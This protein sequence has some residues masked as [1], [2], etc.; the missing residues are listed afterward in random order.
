L[1]YYF[2]FS[3]FYFLNGMSNTHVSIERVFRSESGQVLA[4][5]IGWLR[6]FELAEDV[7][8]DAF[9]EALEH[10]VATGV[11]QRP[12][13][14]LTQVARRKAV[15]RLRRAKHLAGSAALATLASAPELPEPDEIPDERL[16]L[17]CTCCHPALPLEAQ[18]ALTLQTLGGLN[19]AEIAYAFL[20]PLPTM[21]QR[22]VRAK[23]KIKAAGIPY[24][25]PSANQLGERLDAIHH[26]LYLIFTEGYG[27]SSGDALIRQEL[28]DEAIRLARILSVLIGHS[29]EPI[30]PAQHA[31]TLGLLAL[32]LL[33][34][35]RRV[36]RLD[37]EGALVLL[38]DQDRSRWDQAQIGMGKA[39]LAKALLM[40]Q[41][42][43]YQIQ[44]AISALHAEAARPEDTDWPQIAALYNS[45]QRMHNTPVI[46]LNRAVAIGMASGP[47]ASL[48]LL[49]QIAE[50]GDLQEYHPFHLALADTLRRLGRETEARASYR[51]ALDLCQ[52]RVERAAIAQQLQR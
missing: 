44:A 10:W 40:H 32:M 29:P 19:T 4:T 39:L 3:L 30:P 43:P 17:I 42:G 5:L 34:H 50:R 38:A 26:V 41:P 20:V 27:A 35:S 21:A 46:E 33:H 47:G 11:P 22:L 9:I 52:N 49:M 28:C 15:D 51:R 45:L 14:W 25:V 36:A 12:G 18:V 7:L 8:Q 23:R 6:D 16:K 1:A 37:A 48:P 2:L 31:E 24:L 13:A